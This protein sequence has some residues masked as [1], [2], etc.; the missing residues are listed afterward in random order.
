MKLK[1]SHN[2]CTRIWYYYSYK[3]A[4]VA[5]QV[6][7]SLVSEAGAGEIVN[8]SYYHSQLYNQLLGRNGD[9]TVWYFSLLY[10]YPLFFRHRLQKEVISKKA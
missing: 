6:K 1:I 3:P 8:F 4:E 7:V 5:V 9:R 2:A 10:S